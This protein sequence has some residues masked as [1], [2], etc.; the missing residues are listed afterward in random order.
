M[1]VAGVVLALAGVAFLL[2]CCLVAG[3]LGDKDE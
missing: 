2:V 1:V 3:S